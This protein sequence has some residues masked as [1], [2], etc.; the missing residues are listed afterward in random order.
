M[1]GGGWAGVFLTLDDCKVLF[2]R[3]KEK[4]PSLSGEERA[5]LFK[6][7]KVLYGSLSVREMEELLKK[8]APVSPG[9]VN[10]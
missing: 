7:E 9:S 8:A 3:L 1:D 4:E 6:M 2:P 10:V 5:I